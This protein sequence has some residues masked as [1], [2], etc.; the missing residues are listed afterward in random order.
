MNW[1][2][3]YFK[4]SSLFR[5]LC[6]WIF[7]GIVSF[8][9]YFL[10]Q[11]T[12]GKTPEIISVTPHI[13]SDDDTVKI[14]GINFGDKE[15]E[16]ILHIGNLFISSFNCTSW[17]DT[18]IVFKTPK[19]FDTALLDVSVKGKVSLPVMLTAKNR[20]PVISENKQFSAAPEITS[21]SAGRGTVGTLLSIYGS[22]FGNSREN[23]QVI[24]TK[25]SENILKSTG[26][27]G[28]TGA[29]CSE[30]EF[31]FIKWSDSE[32]KIRVPDAAVTGNIVVVTGF[33][34]SNPV[35]FMVS[36]K[37]GKKELTNKRTYVLVSEATFSNFK[38][39]ENNNLFVSVPIPPVSYR[40]N[41]VKLLTT[42]PQA[43]AL[44]Y[45]GG[46]IHKFENLNSQSK[47]SIYQE[48][49]IDTYDVTTKVNPV[50]VH[51]RIKLKPEILIYTKPD[52][53]IPSNDEEIKKL[54]AEIIKGRKN[55]YNNAK[56]IHEYIIKNIQP[57]PL[58]TTTN[59]ETSLLSAIEQKVADSYD[60]AIMFCAL[61]RAANIPA[62][63][64]AGI[65]VD[66]NQKSHTHFWAEFYIDGLGWIPVDPAL[67]LGLPF[68][69][70]KEKLPRTF[71]YLDGYHIAF[72]RGIMP[73]TQ[74]TPG[75][76][77][78]RKQRS[79]ALRQYFEETSKITAYTSFWGIPK[80]ITIY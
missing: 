58:S 11:I 2:S 16:S 69:T 22:G 3:Y 76:K 45:Q 78:V 71:G 39:K 29:S 77:M 10:L 66:L 50:N 17:S 8:I 48:Y 61:A 19:N 1:F 25:Q 46:I 56:L 49:S 44:N 73:Q 24:F 21:L 35:P 7:L 43:F 57:K 18:E 40:Q 33:S 14:K 15:D 68:A 60:I 65:M 9:I 51:A 13:V 23:S 4:K 72:S 63:P 6:F 38:C 41:K 37:I 55:P 64:I 42:K 62:V 54:S 5:F 70:A 26:I 34:M 67:S 79:Y 28:L 30:S 74:M 47:I 27:S 31:D 20:L 75:G 52:M 59:F 12:T 80:V 36:N 53:Y 32:I